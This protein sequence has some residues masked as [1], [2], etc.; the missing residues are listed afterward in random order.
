[1]AKTKSK[2]KIRSTRRTTITSIPRIE[3]SPV[4]V[5]ENNVDYYCDMY[6]ADVRK[7][8][9]KYSKKHHGKP[10]PTR[11]YNVICEKA[12]DKLFRK[13]C[14]DARKIERMNE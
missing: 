4:H 12:E 6:L 11:K 8:K 10:I 1:M 5:Y 3:I 14:E 2:R 9:E 7:G 13:V